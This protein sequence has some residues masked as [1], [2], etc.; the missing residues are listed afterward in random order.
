MMRRLK[1]AREAAAENSRGRVDESHWDGFPGPAWPP[2]EGEPVRVLAHA[3]AC[4]GEGQ[5]SYWVELARA[6]P[7]D[8]VRWHFVVDP[9]VGRRGVSDGAVG[10]CLREF[11]EVTVLPA[12]K[13]LRQAAVRQ[14][15]LDWRPHVGHATSTAGAQYLVECGLPVVLAR[16]GVEGLSACDW[17][18]GVRARVAQS[19]AAAGANPVGVEVI[20]NGIGYVEWPAVRRDGVVALV[21]R[22]DADRNPELV[23]E[24]IA[25]VPEAR[26]EVVGLGRW[27]EFDPVAVAG[28]LGCAD[29][30]TWH[31]QVSREEAQAIAGGADVVVCAT[32]EGFGYGLLEGILGGAVPVV[33][34]GAG[35]QTVL[36]QEAGG[37]VTGCDP[38]ELAVGIRKALALR[39]S[40]AERRQVARRM[41]AKY[42]AEA[43]AQGY[44]EVYRRVLPPVVD[45]ILL[46]SGEAAITR[47]CLMHVL[48]NTWWPY[49]LILIDNGSVGEEVWW[50]MQQAAGLSGMQCV[51]LRCEEDRGC[52]G[53]RRL[54]LEHSEADYIV[55]LD[56]DMLV[57]AGWLGPLIQ[58]ML[59]HPDAGAVGAWWSAYG[60]PPAGGPIRRNFGCAAALLRRAA[61]PADAYATPLAAGQVGNDTD[62]LWTML[63]AGWKLYLEP[64]SY[65]LHL[66]GP[67][68]LAGMTRRK[69]LGPGDEREARLAFDAKWAAPGVRR[70]DE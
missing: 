10:E 68:G 48:A 37:I 60:P 44:L 65:W 70:R 47:A 42:R 40:E 61:L 2:G 27:R 33:V 43:M 63:E 24:A 56:N 31:G 26:L 13:H 1:R 39:R 15:V 18:R 38:A 25:L 45:I 35:Y 6:V 62:V 8:R 11:G 54:G 14:V 23:L 55:T 29:R 21:G 50:V 67:P 32:Q 53:G 5:E 30:V 51:L 12:L 28:G 58:T 49:R 46:A 4:W 36:A 19:S 16:D 34:S 17:V 66:G 7:R 69:V 22:L 52:A 41:A 59:S 20:P 57:P 3:F 9:P 64:R